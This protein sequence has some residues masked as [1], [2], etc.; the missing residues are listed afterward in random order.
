MSSPFITTMNP[1]QA[2]SRYGLAN[3]D[4]PVPPG[5]SGRVWLSNGVEFTLQ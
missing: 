5:L 2:G 4:I 1:T 3:L